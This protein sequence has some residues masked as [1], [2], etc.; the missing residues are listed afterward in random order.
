MEDA[1]IIIDG[2]G[3][4]SIPARIARGMTPTLFCVSKQAQRKFWEFFTAHIRNPNTRRAYLIAVWRFA[5]QW[6]S[7]KDLLRS[8][9]RIP[10][11]GRL[12]EAGG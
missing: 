8:D 6:H 9:K 3:G 2:Q 7:D 10:C 5:D 1:P 11:F 4:S 12:P